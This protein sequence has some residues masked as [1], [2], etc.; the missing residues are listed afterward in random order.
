MES[1]DF[2]LF[3]AL[4]LFYPNLLPIVNIDVGCAT[5]VSTINT[6]IIL[7]QTGKYAFAIQTAYVQTTYTVMVSP[8]IY[9]NCYD[10]ICG[11]G[12]K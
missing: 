7:N 5:F 11:N 9:I 12:I 1:T 4:N 3:S 2:L 10:N 6:T 8:T